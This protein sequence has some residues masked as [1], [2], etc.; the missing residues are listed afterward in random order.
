MEECIFC[1]IINGEIPSSKV[2]END[3]VIAFLDIA[4]VNKGHTLVVPKEHHKDIMDTPD[5][6][7]A[8]TI[9]AVKKVA[10][11]V[12]KATGAEGFNL[13]VNNG[14]IAGQLVMHLHFH[15][16]PRFENDGLKLWPGRKYEGNEIDEI[17]KKISSL[18]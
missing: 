15:I 12:M 13:G 10:K 1:K 6:I 3:K 7:L 9:K 18:L 11:A 5:N 17:A 14:K 2:Y 4:P 8:E 16:M